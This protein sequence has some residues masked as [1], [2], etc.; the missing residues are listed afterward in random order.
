MAPESQIRLLDTVT[1]GSALAFLEDADS[2]LGVVTPDRNSVRSA[3]LAGQAFV[4]AGFEPQKMMLTM[5]RAGS[6]GIKPEEMTAELGRL[7]D[8]AIPEDPGLV[9]STVS[10]GVP[11]VL[12]QPDARASR[13]ITSIAQ[14]LMAPPA[15]ATVPAAPAP[16]LAPSS[17]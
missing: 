15:R 16:T 6:P 5:N 2:I 17:T 7:P 13:E 12:A 8:V 1:E 3:C 10:E 11:F 9:A 4:A 14:R